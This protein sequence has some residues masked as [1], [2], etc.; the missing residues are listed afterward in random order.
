MRK[1]RGGTNL[2]KQIEKYNGNPYISSQP[3]SER[4][5]L[6]D[7]TGEIHDSH[8]DYIFL[9]ET[10]ATPWGYFLKE[11]YKKAYPEEKLPAFY[12]VNPS[13]VVGT[14]KE[15]HDPWREIKRTARE[16]L[17]EF[18][19]VRIKKENPRVVIFDEMYGRHYSTDA[20]RDALEEYGVNP[21]NISV[22]LPSVKKE[23]NVV[24][25]LE[26]TPH[27]GLTSK[28]GKMTSDP[29]RWENEDEIRFTGEILHYDTKSKLDYIH[30]AKEIGREIGDEI[31]Q[32]NERR[33]SL[34]SR[35][36]SIISIVFFL[37]SILFS[38]SNFTGNIVGISHS[39]LNFFG[40]IFFILGIFTSAIWMARKTH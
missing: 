30:D 7:I 9:T 1:K 25:G 38:L 19:K 6:K 37:A 17:N 18:F 26:L 11:A 35:L 8:P 39:S 5:V 15:T 36:T 31:R 27:A 20:V 33:A 23:G 4:E 3:Y 12:R 34:E 2:R 28:K 24:A 32:E 40:I 21:K 10:S 13:A 22:V 29:T 14:K 16:K